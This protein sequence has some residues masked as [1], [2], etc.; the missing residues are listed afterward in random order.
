MNDGDSNAGRDDSTQDELAR[1]Q[2]VEEAMLFTQHGQDQLAQHVLELG[3]M[4]A[5]LDQRL[6]RMEELSRRLDDATRGGSEPGASE[7]A[8]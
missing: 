3:R 5:R 7:D 8:E 4:L 1:L 2:R 6:A